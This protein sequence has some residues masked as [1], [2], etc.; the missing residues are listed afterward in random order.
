VLAPWTLDMYAPVY[1]DAC[2]PWFAGID[3]DAWPDQSAQPKTYD[4]LVY[5]KIRWWHDELE[6]SLLQPLL[7]KLSM[8]GLTYH[9]MRYRMHDHATFKQMLSGARGM[10]FICEHET[11]GLAYQE[12]M[13]S[14]VPV[15]AWDNG[16]WADPLWKKF[17]PSA[18]PASS[19]PFFSPACGETFRDLSG[20]DDALDR[21]MGKRAGYRPRDYVA[22]NLDMETS[23]SLYA[24]QYFSLITNKT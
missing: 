16:F 24:E 6:Q 1:G 18:P 10:L 17:Q 15:L 4:F 3:L 13:A 14:G 23:A 2:F 5:D 9:V 11:Q 12:A 20:F 8:K 19:V 7:Q 22:K 21:F